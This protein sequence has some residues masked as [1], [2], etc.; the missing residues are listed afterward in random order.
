MS[1]YSL[2][3]EELVPIEGWLIR[4][5]VGVYGAAVPGLSLCAFSFTDIS[6]EHN[7]RFYWEP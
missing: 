7:V 5:F 1:W 3:P 4:L 6:C 2:L